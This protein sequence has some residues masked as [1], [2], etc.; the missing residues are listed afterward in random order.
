M[1]YRTRVF[2]MGSSGADC[3][4]GNIETMRP[5][6]VGQIHKI[7]GRLWKIEKIGKNMTGEQLADLVPYNRK[8]L[9]N[10]GVM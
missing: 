4:A 5:V 6:A 10:N 8:Q 9:I 3:E 2:C 7:K 1:S